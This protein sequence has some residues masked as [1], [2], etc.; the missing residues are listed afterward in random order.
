[1]AQPDAAGAPES[2]RRHLERLRELRGREAREGAP[3]R[4]PEVKAFQ[5]RRLAATYRDLASDPRYAPATAFFLGDL[6]GTKDFSARDEALL[7]IYPYMVRTLPASA[8][9][10]AALAIEVDALSEEMDRLLADA[11][12]PGPLDEAS[13]GRAWRRLGRRAERERQVELVDAVGR[14]LDR[15]VKRPIIRAT[16]RLMRKP[17]Q[18]A[19][20]EE[21]QRFLERGFEA[22]AHMDGADHFLATIARREGEVLNRLFSGHPSPFSG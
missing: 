12:D 2:L 1:M 13:Y 3:P 20:L 7:K 9:E 22:F 15:L 19:G 6:Y 14:R 16:L 18:L 4:L 10:T 5:A 17:A 8:V 11:L 21:L